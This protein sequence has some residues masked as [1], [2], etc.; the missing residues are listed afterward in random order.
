[1]EN[2]EN[3]E[4]KINQMEEGKAVSGVYYLLVRGY[5]FIP[6]GDEFLGIYSEVAKL[7]LAY[8][9]ECEKLEELQDSGH[10]RNYGFQIY[11]FDEKHYGDE[12]GIKVVKPEELWIETV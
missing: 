6:D 8:L 2:C 10:Y 11:I 3:L 7:K 1:M 9:R 4:K 12:D 5:Y